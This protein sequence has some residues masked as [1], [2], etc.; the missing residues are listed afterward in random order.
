MATMLFGTTIGLLFPASASWQV[1]LWVPMPVFST[2]HAVAT[3]QHR[4]DSVLIFLPLSWQYTSFVLWD[5]T[6][7]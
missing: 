7:D 1:V 3:I 4:A 5:W 2:I 6:W